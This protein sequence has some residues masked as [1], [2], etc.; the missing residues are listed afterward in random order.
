MNKN[1]KKNKVEIVHDAF[2]IGIILKG[3]DGI[4]EIVGG[5]VVLFTTP[6]IFKNLVIF[7]TKNELIQDPR[8]IFANYLLRL[9]ASFTVKAEHF[10]SIFLLSHGVIKV[11]LVIAMLQKRL[12]AYPT[13]MM[14]F[15]LFGVYQ[16]Y[17]YSINHS[18]FLILLTA[19]DVAVIILTYLE[20][21]NLKT[22]RA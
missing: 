22:E 4:I 3:I 21:K 14:I 17:Q 11:F 9:S 8:D 1:D 20:Y 13:A 15:G 2:E 7:L 18:V 12:W 10:T 5:I 6:T 16:I 19:L